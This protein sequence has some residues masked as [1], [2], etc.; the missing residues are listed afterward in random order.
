MAG[1]SR[2]LEIV[3]LCL[4]CLRLKLSGRADELPRTLYARFRELGGV[5]IK[6]LQ[7]LVVQ[8]DA[9]RNL[10]EYD[11]Y[12][13]Y[14]QVQYDPLD[15]ER[16]LTYELGEN[17]KELKLESLEPFAAGSFGQVYRAQYKG[18]DVVIKVLRPSI[19]K[20]LSGDLRTLGWLSRVIDLA[21][22]DSAVS[23]RQVCRDLARATRAETDYILEADYASKLYDRYKD[24]PHIYIPYTFREVSTKHLICQEYVGGVA[25]TDVLRAVEA[26]HDPAAYVTEVTGS[27]LTEQMVGL[28]V[29]F[30]YSIFAHGAT[31][32]DPHPGNIKFL[33]NNRVGLIDYGLQG[34]APKNLNGFYNVVKQT[35]N[36][37]NGRPDIRSYCLAILEM[38]G[39]DV[40]LAARSLEAHMGAGSQIIDDIMLV[41]DK[42]FQEGGS[43]TKSLLE[44]NRL[45]T[46]FTSIV[47]KD[48]QFCLRYNIDG[49]EM[50]RASNLFIK[51][52][53]MLGIRKE[54]MR[55]TYAEVIAKVDPAG[56][57]GTPEVLHPE[58]ALE[59]IAAW[60]DQVSY[61]NP[62]LH[63]Q[64]MQRSAKYV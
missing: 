28:G 25:A 57:G 62:Q 8:S 45:P 12:D 59:T 44:E 2:L 52:V 23:A 56:L 42:M 35:S 51:L 58:T 39:G 55:R 10:R 41:A 38:Y 53:R 19:M 61:R 4:L 3:K 26:G 29:E 43:Q 7:L 49:V 31:Y 15:I 40:I 11:V 50:M 27:D 1:N 47:N 33:A 22:Q 63:R 34:A 13:I 64:I 14:D 9:F 37:Y 60:V 24:H 48:N 20:R 6:F 18:R 54:V 36:I 21:T 16:L 17:A 32:G 5:Y 46:I 30:L